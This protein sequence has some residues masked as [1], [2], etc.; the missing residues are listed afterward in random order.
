MTH[1]RN[2]RSIARVYIKKVYPM[3]SVYGY[4]L[5]RV[6]EHGD[7][8]LRIWWRPTEDTKAIDG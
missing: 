7:I 8:P 6:R 1:I 4:V 3:S 5:P 2:K